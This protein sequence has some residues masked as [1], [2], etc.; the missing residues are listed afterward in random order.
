MKPG[1]TYEERFEGWFAR[2]IEKLRELPEGDGGFLALSAA[3]FLC[4][5]Y[6]R[7]K[8]KTHEGQEDN[9]S[10]KKTAANDL[11][12]SLEDFK[13][14]WNVYR[15]GIQHQG[16]PRKFTDKRTKVTYRWR[17]DGRF[18]AIPEIRKIDEC[19]SE[20]RLDPWKF[21]ERIIEKF[22]SEPNVLKDANIHAFGEVGYD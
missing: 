12:L 7:T 8:T 17:I 13:V 16:M 22:R 2:P 15:L 9:E 3:L 4:E 6:Y 14:F 11:G 10:F 1:A 21:A 18:S 5:R 20:I 19:T